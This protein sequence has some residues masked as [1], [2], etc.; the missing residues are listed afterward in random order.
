MTFFLF[1][2]ILYAPISFPFRRIIY[3]D[4]KPENVGFDRLGQL[5]LFDFG[6]AKDLNKAEH[7]KD[8]LYKLTGLTGSARYMAP[9]VAKELPYN[10]KCDVYALA[11]L[12]WE[13]MALKQPYSKYNVREMFQRVYDTPHVRPNLE[14]LGVEREWLADLLENMWISLI[15]DR[16]TVDQVLPVLE[17]RLR[18]VQ[19]QQQKQQAEKE[20][21]SEEGSKD[22]NG[23]Q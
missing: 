21:G 16:W 3:R 9:E 8:G 20:S 12:I 14:E 23:D 10:S 18:T 11:I 17:D 5:K 4:L 1:T 6:L 7:L 2:K 19:Q 15:A 22:K 13:V